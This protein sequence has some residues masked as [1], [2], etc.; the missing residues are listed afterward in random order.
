MTI[1]MRIIYASGVSTEAKV[2]KIKNH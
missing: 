1:K 2:K